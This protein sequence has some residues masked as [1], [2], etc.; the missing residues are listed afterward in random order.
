MRSGMGTK[1]DE[2]GF[3]TFSTKVM[4]DCFALPSSHEGSGSAALV[5][6]SLALS[7]LSAEDDGDSE[8]IREQAPRRG[9]S[10]SLIYEIACSD[11]HAAH[12]GIASITLATLVGDEGT[13][14]NPPSGTLLSQAT[15]G[16]V[17]C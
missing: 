9:Y 5:S 14:I 17:G 13:P 15:C 8:R 2:P 7:R 4:M 1:P 3:V 10:K 11:S 6:G 16:E 12:R